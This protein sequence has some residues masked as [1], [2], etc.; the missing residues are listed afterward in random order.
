[1]WPETP[2]Y[3]T[4]DGEVWTWEAYLDMIDNTPMTRA[5]HEEALAFA[6]L[7]KN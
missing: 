5:E 1:M 4:M 3:V 7:N 2:G 6:G